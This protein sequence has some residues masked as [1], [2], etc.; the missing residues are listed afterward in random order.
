[1]KNVRRFYRFYQNLRDCAPLSDWKCCH[2]LDV[3]HVLYLFKDM[4]IT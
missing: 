2:M 4:L 3:E 1:M